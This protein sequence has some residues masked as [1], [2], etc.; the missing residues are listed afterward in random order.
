[1][2]ILKHRVF[3]CFEYLIIK[4]VAGGEIDCPKHSLNIND[5]VGQHSIERFF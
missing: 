4:N 2:E 1:M 3:V 5:N